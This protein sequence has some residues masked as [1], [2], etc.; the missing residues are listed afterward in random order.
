[1]INIKEFSFWYPGISQPAL[2]D[3]TLSIGKGEF[4]LL[5]GP[6]GCGK[7]TLLLAMNGVV[8]Q[9]T[10]G[11]VK[12]RI[13]IN[14]MDT[15]ETP[16]SKLS[17]SVGLILQDPE[18]Q[19]TNLFVYDEIAFGPEN[20]NLAEE[21]I[22]ERVDEALDLTGINHLK[23]RS[24][25]ALSGGQKQRVA[26]AAALAMK[27]SILLLD[28]P[29]SNLDPVGE[30]ETY[31][32]IREMRLNNPELTIVLAEHRPDSIVDL[33]DRLIV[34]DKGR[35][36][37]SGEPRRVY[38]SL[39]MQLKDD[40]GVFLPQTTEFAIELK[41]RNY[42]IKETPLSVEEVVSAVLDLDI[43]WIENKP[44]Q[45]EQGNPE[46]QIK[47][48][49]VNISDVHFSYQTGVKAVN[50]ASLSISEGE[51]VCFVGENGSGKTTLAKL[52]VGLL[53][54]SNGTIELFEKDLQSIP[55]QELLGS[56]G[57]VFQYPD[58]Q[59]I[60]NNVY[61]EIAFSLRAMKL[62]EE[63]IY[64]RV[65][66]ALKLFA[67][68]NL[69]KSSPNMLSKGQKRRLSVATMLVT[70][71]KL[72]IL[73]EPMTGQDQYNIVNLLSILNDLRKHGTSIIDITHDMEHV[74]SF[75]D[76][77]IGLC[78]GKIIFDGAPSTL[79]DQKSVLDKLHIK[80]PP[81]AEVIDSLKMKGL[82][83][84]KETITLDQVLSQISDQDWSN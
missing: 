68:D 34:I 67:L 74:A 9:L 32:T 45:L 57:Y 78:E 50:G 28:N 25:F 83:I 60:T 84:S 59:F 47:T 21:Q 44:E 23:S 51:F 61:D 56:V 27:P 29:T 13:Q 24:V 12:G 66:N 17:G 64:I 33:A 30:D 73:D 16:V 3:V 39:G 4:N 75:A 41:R 5:V 54:P 8:P 82:P 10:G 46:S 35:V 77:V 62:S 11:K 22:V 6:S 79:F 38:S 31:Q 48:D 81:I 2:E 18:S 71:P 55:L 37:E 72:L 26:I 76:R 36:I 70:R 80:A 69:R 19:L 42:K 58:H 63:E 14:Q 53:K 52:M 40:Y 65:E 15:R 1:M 49:V 20:L 7:S 43:N